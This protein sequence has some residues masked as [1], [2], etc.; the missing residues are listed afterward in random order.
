MI[1]MKAQD[2][3]N[4]I[5][6]LIPVS[7]DK[8]KEY[9]G[10]IVCD[11]S[12]DELEEAANRLHHSGMCRFTTC[13]AYDNRAVDNSFHVVYVFDC[14]NNLYLCLR[15]KLPGVLPKTRSLARIVDAPPCVWCE[16]EAKEL[17]GIEFEGHPGKGRF[18]LPD[19]WPENF[20]PMR[21]DAPRP[22]QPSARSGTVEGGKDKSAGLPI[23]PFHPALHEPEFFELVVD[24]ERIVDA[25][26]RGFFV[27]RGIEKLAEER[28][29]Y[30]QI[31]F[32]AER[33]C[34]ICGFTHSIAYCQAVE[35]ALDIEVPPRAQYIRA[36]L[37]EI[38]RIHSHILWAAIMFHI[39]GFDA[40]F[41]HLMAL[42][43]EV[44]SIAEEITG[45][46]KTY[47]MVLPG[48]V[49]RDVKEEM[50]KT[51]ADRLE[52]VV[53]KA[54]KLAY[55]YLDVAEVRSRF[56]EVGMLSREEALKLGALGPVARASSVEVD[57]RRDHPYA[58]YPELEFNVVVRDEG[59]VL[60][61]FLVRLEELM[62]S[63]RIVKQIAELIPKTPIM[64]CDYEY[65]PF[66][67]AVAATEAPRGEN[68]HFI[69]TGN[70]NRI[71]RWRVRAPSYNNISLLPKM[72]RGYQVADA[73]V[74]ITSIDPC[75]S[76]TDRL[77]VV[78]SRAKRAR[79]LSLRELVRG[80]SV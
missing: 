6:K 23:G 3:T 75:F 74:I 42:R 41:M 57:V 67:S 60:A 65:K 69:V 50:L 15:L 8:C 9:K 25:K 16:W 34:G 40:G 11:V 71:W 79:V 64:N 29:T 37:L 19:S 18:I 26:Y 52:R 39:V 22:P 43:E 58:A 72:L 54:V 70:A 32:L 17:Y 63:L 12:T 68:L 21:K 49:R 59:D 80:G 24:G 1:P 66:A 47:S 61:R 28:F 56:E 14:R 38:E 4:P 51:I 30:D 20:H 10:F 55:S 73:P 33:V 76:C 53:G 44:M 2:A 45:N 78:D 48:G 7:A 77:L 35:R 31:P 62:E 5:F 27:Y 36:L 13:L 46:R